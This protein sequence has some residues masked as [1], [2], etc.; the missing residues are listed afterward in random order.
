MKTEELKQLL[1]NSSNKKI[2]FIGR[3][4]IFTTKEIERFLK[5]YKI[6]RVTTLQ[7]SVIATVEHHSLNPI[8]EM[9]SDESYDLKIPLIPL[10]LFERLLSENLNDD[11]VLMGIK[12]SN[13]QSRVLR[14]VQNHDISDTLFVK[15]LEMYQW[16]LDEDDNNDD[17]SV[18]IATLTRYI[19]ITPDER[20]QLYSVLTLKRLVKECNDATLLYALLNFPNY[21]FKQKDKQQISFYEVIATSEAIDEKVIKRLLAL[22]NPKVDICLASNRAVSLERLLV[23]AV[24]DD[25]SINL[26]LARNSKINEA[27]FERLLEAGDKV[28]MRLLHS[29]PI[30]NLRL[31]KIEQRLGKDTLLNEIG[32]NIWLTD[33]VKLILIAR[34]DL[35]LLCSLASNPTLTFKMIERIYLRNIPQTH[36]AIAQNPH[37]VAAILE[38]F[39]VDYPQDNVM[40]HHIAANPNTPEIVLKELF[41]KEEIEIYKGLASNPSTPIEILD[42]LKI[43]TRLR[44]ALTHNET[45][46]HHHNT[47]KVVI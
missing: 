26:A 22:H 23:F 36:Y 17:R 8:E 45:F 28:I 47:T 1:Q 20:D 15:L 7:E 32:K 2:L 9:L 35:F 31:A 16:H 24:R 39:Y 42:I 44:H 12:L 27:I 25:E 14:M 13:D 10:V 33:E 29:Q 41:A 3:E 43:D 19:K 18:V 30:D 34:N 5:P 46:I 6:E 37:T 40:L 21:T 4:G 38:Q 11:A